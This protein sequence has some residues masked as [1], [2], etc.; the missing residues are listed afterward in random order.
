M[1]A[2]YMPTGWLGI[3]IGAKIY[4]KFLPTDS[5][6]KFSQSFAS[7]LKEIN[8]YTSDTN[9]SINKHNTAVIKSITSR[10]CKGSFA[11]IFYYIII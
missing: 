10:N 1:Q 4:Y 7:M 8:S 9:K 3:I 11:L 2:D 5:D 6:L